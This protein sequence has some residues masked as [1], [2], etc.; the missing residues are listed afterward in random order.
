MSKR[1]WALFF[2][3]GRTEEPFFLD[4][5]LS[6]LRLP[7]TTEATGAHLLD[8]H[9]WERWLSISFSDEQ[10]RWALFFTWASLDEDYSSEEQYEM[11]TFCQVSSRDEHRFF[12]WA[13]QN[14]SLFQMRKLVAH[15]FSRGVRRMS[16]SHQMS[17][18]FWASQAGSTFETAWTQWRQEV[19]KVEHKW[20][21]GRWA[22]FFW[23]AKNMSTFF[24][25]TKLSWALFL[26]WGRWDEHFSQMSKDERVQVKCRR[27]PFI[28]R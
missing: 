1:R 15:L 11:S 13:T 19:L 8:E 21:Q 2:R 10:Q 24:Q 17:T 20:E 5:H 28:F 12:R 7:T 4:E 3:W 23:C 6:P 18:H 9:C 16:T 27:A 25:L 22:L 14:V 26:S